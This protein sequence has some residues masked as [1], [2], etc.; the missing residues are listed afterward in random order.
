MAL[1]F[2]RTSSGSVINLLFTY[3]RNIPS[4]DIL[5][6]PIDSVANTVDSFKEDKIAKRAQFCI[7]L[8][9]ARFY[10][11]CL[12]DL[13]IHVRIDCS[14]PLCLHM[15]QKKKRGERRD[16]KVRAGV[17]VGF[18]DFIPA[19]NDRIKIR[20]NRGLWTA[21]VRKL[22][23]IFSDDT[24]FTLFSLIE[25]QIRFSNLVKRQW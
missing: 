2:S 1:L 23:K 18:R 8:R 13:L 21:Y 15:R 3:N 4:T 24:S 14:Q 12:P 6:H 9:A 22:L 7:P 17:G 11:A 10:L 19:F 16:R 25:L 20:E 5:A